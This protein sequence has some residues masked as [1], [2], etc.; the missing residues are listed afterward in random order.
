MDPNGTS[1]EYD[2]IYHYTTL[3]FGYM[4]FTTIAFGGHMFAMHFMTFNDEVDCDFNMYD[5]ATLSAMRSAFSTVTS[6]EVCY[7]KMP[8]F[9]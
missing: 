4:L 1:A 5:D 8:G 9:L 7:E 2:I 3:M 6:L